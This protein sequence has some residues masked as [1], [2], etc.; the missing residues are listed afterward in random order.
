[1][2]KPDS[3]LRSAGFGD[4]LS[5]SPRLRAASCENVSR[6]LSSSVVTVAR[7]SGLT[8][9]TSYRRNPDSRLKALLET[10]RLSSAG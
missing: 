9:L 1:M 8:D 7:N 5:R 3:W 6:A 10:S 4:P 2:V